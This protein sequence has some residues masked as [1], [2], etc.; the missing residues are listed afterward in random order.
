MNVLIVDD[1]RS[2]LALFAHLL[3]GIS[4]A[5][6][7]EESD[8]EQ[9][10]RWCATHQADV[11]LLDYMMPKMDGLTFLQQFR[12]LYGD[13]HVPVIMV[14]ADAQQ[15]VRHEALLLSANDFM[16]KPVNRLE[17]RARVGN[18]LALRRSQHQQTKRADILQHDVNRANEEARTLTQELVTR[19]T[20]AAGYRDPETGAHL[21]RMSH[22]ARLIAANLGMSEEEQELI[23]RAA[24]LHDVGKIGIPDHILHKPGKL[25]EEEMAVMRTHPVIGAALLKD[26]SS[27]LMKLAAEISLTHHEKYDGSGYPA[28]LRGDAIPIGGRIVAVADVFDALTSVRPYKVA[29]SIEDALDL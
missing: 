15:T 13:D 29:W 18:M 19:L 24:P 4:D 6:L 21:L 22:Y 23:F 11:L 1:D 3:E 8:P 5:T 14:T 10:L 9:A 28:G 7:I 16:T 25:T 17:L 26:A 20:A 2:N 27:P 12:Q